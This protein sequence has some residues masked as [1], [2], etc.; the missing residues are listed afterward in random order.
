MT[1]LP[2]APFQ[3]TLDMTP[4]GGWYANLIWSHR[5]Y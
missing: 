5:V 2:S 1:A 3:I 4:L